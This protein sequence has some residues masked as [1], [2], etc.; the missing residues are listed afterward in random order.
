MREYSIQSFLDLLEVKGLL[1]QRQRAEA[2]LLCHLNQADRLNLRR[3]LIRFAA[4]AL[5]ILMIGCFYVLFFVISMPLVQKALLMSAVG[6]ML[7]SLPKVHKTLQNLRHA[8]K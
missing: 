8:R 3:I 4:S 5:V 1:K 6:M 2:A 7:Y